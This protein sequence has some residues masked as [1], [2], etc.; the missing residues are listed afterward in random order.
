M[1]IF[2]VSHYDLDL[3]ANSGQVFRWVRAAAGSYT[4]PA[5]GRLCKVSQRPLAPA[6]GS[7]RVR[8]E[9]TCDEPDVAFWERYLALDDDYDDVFARIHALG[10]SWMDQ[11]LACS[12]G[13]RVLHQ[14]LFETCV[15]FMTSSNN[16]IPRITAS[17]ER[18]C[19]GPLAPFPSPCELHG[20][21]ARDDCGL[22]YRRPWMG[23]LCDAFPGM[24][25]RLGGT[26]EEDLATLQ[27]LNGIG[28]KVAACIALFALDHRDA[29][30]VDTW[31][32]KAHQAH[33]IK[34]VPDIAGIQ[35]QFIFHHMRAA[36]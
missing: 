19:G 2:E 12:D 18:M 6:T 5:A 4:I 29:Y 23:A 22:G 26:T 28:P 11:V 3:I 31:M 24:E 1:R 25:A 17:I 7:Q 20:V 32:R 13:V 27:T 15:T 30:P 8:V 9:L 34:L 16:N 36:R 35:Q 10:D 14:P 21:V 33:P